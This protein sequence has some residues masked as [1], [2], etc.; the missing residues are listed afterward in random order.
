MNVVKQLREAHRAELV[1]QRERPRGIAEAQP[2]CGINI[3]GRRNTL[4]GN[5]TANCNDHRENSRRYKTRAVANDRNANAVGSKERVRRV[6]VI[7]A[8]GRRGHE[9]SALAR[10]LGDRK[11]RVK[12]DGSLGRPIETGVGGVVAKRG[13]KNQ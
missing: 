4:L 2:D 13:E 5:L 3:G 8:G 7:G 12:G 9:C 6:A 10:A 11:K 1:A